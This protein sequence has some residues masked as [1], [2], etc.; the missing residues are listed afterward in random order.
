MPGQVSRK[1]ALNLVWMDLEMTGLNPDRHV[2][3]EIATVVTDPELNVL[4]EG[5]NLALGRSEEEMASMEAWSART[6]GASGLLDRVR[7]S[8]VDVADA[9]RQTLDF[10]SKWIPSGASP[11]CGNSIHH[12]RRFLRREMPELENYFHYR[13]VD[14]SSVKELVR[15]WYPG[16]PGPSSKPEAHLARDDV[17]ESIAE[18]RWYRDHVFSPATGAEV[19]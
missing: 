10:L 5:P 2:I 14:V 16:V 8:T 1:S 12:D 6:H 3:V 17:L 18:L 9:Q 19:G 7:E 11:L 4:A 15:R 13:I